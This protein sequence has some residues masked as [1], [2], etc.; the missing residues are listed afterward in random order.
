VAHRRLDLP[1][2]APGHRHAAALL[3]PAGAGHLAGRLADL[4]GPDADAY[5]YFNNDP[6]GCA[7]RDARVFALAAARA[8]LRPTRVP[9]AAEVRVG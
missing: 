3:R 5:V 7:V 9:A 4:V 2:P 8:G 6:R 1:A